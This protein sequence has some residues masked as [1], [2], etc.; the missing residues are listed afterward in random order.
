MKKI[1][2]LFKKKRDYTEPVNSPEERVNAFIFHWHKQ[3]STAKRKM[4]K[5]V[6]F[7]YWGNLVSKVDN[8]H[9]VNGSSSVSRGSFGSEP[10]YDPELEKIIECDIQGNFAQIYTQKYDDALKSSSYH[11][12]DLESNADGNW[13]ISGIFVLFYPPKESVIEPDKHAEILRLSNPNAPFVNSDDN[14]NLNENTL[15]QKERSI[16]IPHL[17]KGIAKLDEIGTLQVSSGVLGILDFGYDIYDF[18]PLQKQVIPGEY[19]VETVT[20]YNRVAGIRVRFSENDVPIKWFSANTKNGNGVYGV[21]AGN[22]AI[23]D[24]KNLFNLSRIEK[25]RLFS[26][27]CIS[28]KPQLLSMTDQNDCVIT[29]SGFG[30]GA[31]PA[32]WGVNKDKQLVSLYIDFMILVQETES[33]SY[34]S[35]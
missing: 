26:K 6:D 15:F 4:G 22:L 12:Y 31:Y 29:S 2:E 3:W 18:E 28:G 5:D 32:F 20:I 8:L 19:S 25:E 14:L 9:F 34:V 7:D 21:D 33:G 11:V 10:E 1:I 24:V 35:V 27:W 30:D 23:F 16:N 13:L 17:E